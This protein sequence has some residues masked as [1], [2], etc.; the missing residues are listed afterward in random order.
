MNGKPGGT[1]LVREHDESANKYA[2]TVVY[3]NKATHHLL[4][5]VGGLAA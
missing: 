3:N 4:H 5:K 2:L 1:F